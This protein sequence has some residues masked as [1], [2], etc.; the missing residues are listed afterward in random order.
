M[1]FRRAAPAGAAAVSET[2]EPK[3]L[4]PYLDARREWNERYGSY[5]VRERAWR[6]IAFMSIA[7]AAIAAGGLVWISG[8]SR[9]VPYVVEV[10][11]LGDAVAVRRADQAMPPDNR[12]VR[13]QLAHWITNI[14]SVYVDANAEHEAIEQA[15]ALINQHGAAFG[16]LNDYMR[17][18]GHN[19]FQ[20][21]ANETVSVS[22]QSVLPLT[23]DTWRVEWE[24]TVRDRGGHETSRAVWSATITVMVHAPADDRGVLK[25]P[26]GLFINTLNWSQ[27]L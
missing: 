17:E 8:Q 19:P 23:N 5:I 21:A 12:I 10:D 25:N 22:V 9:V 16:M 24:E 27:R 20:R 15:Y 6:S 26:T 7:V 13:A 2:K 11:K 4:N 1:N 3:E 18:E 14:R